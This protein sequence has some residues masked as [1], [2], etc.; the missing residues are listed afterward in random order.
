[1]IKA[2]QGLYDHEIETCKVGLIGNQNLIMKPG[3][4]FNHW[5]AVVVPAYD[6]SIAGECEAFCVQHCQLLYYNMLTPSVAP[7]CDHGVDKEVAQLRVSSRRVPQSPA[8]LLRFVRDAM[9][10]ISKEVGWTDRPNDHHWMYV[11]KV[12]KDAHAYGTEMGSTFP[13]QSIALQPWSIDCHKESF[14]IMGRDGPLF[15]IHA[16]GVML[17][18]LQ[19]DLSK[20]ETFNLVLFRNLRTC[21]QEVSKLKMK[22]Y[23]ASLG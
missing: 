7:L 11:D 12:P 19:T 20:G 23:R 21:L 4:M 22:R 15:Q 9:A 14:F 5:N 16:D 3:Q 1:M 17:P 6:P 8:H 2:F 13:P 10:L 18:V